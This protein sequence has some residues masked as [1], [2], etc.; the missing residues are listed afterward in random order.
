MSD[1]KLAA[2]VATELLRSAADA[3]D[4]TITRAFAEV[5]RNR[6]VDRAYY[7]RLDEAAGFFELTHEWQAPGLTP[8]AEVPSCTRLPLAIL[9]T[10]LLEALRRGIA[11]PLPRTRG[12]L[13]SPIEDVVAADGDRAVV[14]VPATLDGALLGVA[15][16][17]AACEFEWGPADVELLGIVAQGVARAVERRAVDQALRASE[18]RFRAMCESSPLGIFLADERGECVYLNP[19]GERIMGLSLAEARGIGWKS[20]LHPEDRAR[21]EAHWGSAVGERASYETPVHRFVHEDGDVRSV[22]V[23]AVP[24]ASEGRRGFLGLLEDVTERVRA[25]KE[26]CELY[27]HAQAARAEAEVARAEAEAARAEAEAARAEAEAIV[28]RI[29]DA[30]VALDTEGR[31]RFLNDKAVTLLGRPRDELIGR[32]PWVVERNREGGPF[33]SAFLRAVQEQQPQVVET[34]RPECKRWFELRIYPSPTGASVF[35]EDITDRKGREDEL[36]SDREYL[37]QEVG[38][39]DAGQDAVGFGAGLRHV[40]ERVTLVAASNTSVL[41]TGETGTGKELIARAIHENSPRRERLLVKVNCA[42]ISSGLVESEL[43]GHEKGAFTGAL[44]RRKGRFELAHKGTLLLDE[45]GELPL[46]LQAKLL[47]VLQE[48]EFERVGG[49]ET[50]RVDVRV[51]AATNRD[52]REMVAQGKF[53]EDLYYRLNV[54]PVHLPPLRERPGDVALLAHAFLRRFARQSGKRIAGIAPE[55]LRRL[56]GYRWPG[57]VRELQNVIERAVILAA[58]PDLGPEALPELAPTI[59]AIAPAS[60]AF[61]PRPA[62]GAVRMPYA[63]DQ[64]ERDL[65]AQTLAAT[66]WVI[67]GDRGAA[68][69]LGL[70]PNTL[71][72]RM[73]R[74]GLKRPGERLM[75]V[76][77]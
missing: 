57:N 72:S 70:H 63:I 27:R 34:W 8:M 17:A 7:Y 50:V 59:A 29:D 6:K 39:L 77:G 66:A 20:G 47:R 55:A 74:W 1:E 48:R 46:D 9:P 21:I 54:F 73:K 67:E 18:A 60:L 31:F 32:Q 5:A 53:R 62:T 40:M 43:F 41:V 68:R 58:G 16:F 36:A 37:R 15:G 2:L 28:S 51:I 75:A 76:A 14:L 4:E 45:V 71:R 24:L 52:L 38:G 25:E 30:F 49:S 56:E 13:A 23:R 26:R 3:I 35:V 12:K 61:P 10:P 33:H 69:A 65:V 42:A 64:A 22:S 11:A 19:A 44:S